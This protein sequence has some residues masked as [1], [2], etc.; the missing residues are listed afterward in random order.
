[1]AA[2]TLYQN[3]QA[4][5]W[6][7]PANGFI[8]YDGANFQQLTG[9]VAPTYYGTTGAAPP[10]SWGTVI[11]SPTT[12]GTC[13]WTCKGPGAWVAGAT[14]AVGDVVVVTYTYYVTT[15][16]WSAALH[17]WVTQTT[18]NTV[19]NAFT[20]TI[21]G[22]SLNPGPPS[23]VN[24][25][26]TFT[27]DG[28][29]QWQNSGNPQTWPGATQTLTLINSVIDSA[30]HIQIAQSLGESNDNA[31]VPSWQATKGALT[32]DGN[33]TGG[34]PHPF[35]WL[36]N[37][38]YS[39]G[40][41]TPWLYAYSGLNS[42]TGY[43]TNPSPVSQPIILAANMQPV[44]Q[45]L[46]LADTQFDT[47]ILWRTAAGGTS[48]FYLDQ[49]PNPGANQTWVFTDT[50][51]GDDAL[52]TAESAPGSILSSSLATP[53]PATATAPE[54]HCGRIFVIDGSYVR[55]SGGPDTTTGSGN[56]SFPPLNYF[57]LP[58]QPIKL[59]SATMAGTGGLIVACAANTYVILGE[60]ITPTAISAGNPFLPPKMFMEQIGILSYDCLTMR[61]ST[62]YGF[63][64]KRKAFSFDPG[65][66]ELEIGFPIGDQFRTVTTGGISAAL[67]NP[68]TS[69]VT[70]HEKD[71]TDT[72]LYVSDGSVGWFRWSPIAP[73]ESGS[74]WSPR[75]AIVG[76]TSAVQ[77]VETSLGSFDLLIGPPVSGPILKRDSAQ[78][79]DWTGAAYT[80]FPSYDVKGSIA[81]C[82]TG[83]VAEITHIALK[84]M[85]VGARPTVSL[86]LDEIAAGVTVEGR[87]SDWDTLS[88]DEDRHEDP[89]N[90]DPSITIFS[91]RYKTSS[92]AICPKCENFQLKIDYGAQLFADELLKFA[93]YGATF[94]ERRQ[95]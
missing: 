8:I 52:N 32:G 13:T 28:G 40:L 37:G 34:T 49:F 45:G 26:G 86:L 94:K 88:L 69:Y 25:L 15:T 75:A 36:N 58:D 4:N 2:S 70:W 11:G 42:I 60:G 33:N 44:I 77:S 90:L 84:S 39:A 63:S 41:T 35:N 18:S 22:V 62:I 92:T 27:Q 53:I 80:A 81:L 85:A 20:C 30:G 71:S 66:G 89:P 67:Y 50:S 56:S 64:N 61:G 24:G 29:V 55:W 7:A 57:Q 79:G 54:Y 9:P 6:Y 83:E 72:G 51:G 16:V 82:D 14:H 10:V 19:T 68:A 38:P 93:I 5:T 91:D 12:D 65:N 74:L 17:M 43:I 3:W 76:G 95:Q 47:I 73:P 59:K 87:S 46:G 1:V 48:L 21:G 23:W 78:T 31:H